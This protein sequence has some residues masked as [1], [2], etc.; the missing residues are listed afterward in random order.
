MAGKRIAY[1]QFE[2]VKMYGI[3]SPEIDG[4]FKG[5]ICF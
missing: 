1:V 3:W 5:R 2:F 4:G